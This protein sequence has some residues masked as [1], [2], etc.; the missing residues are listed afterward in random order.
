MNR[1]RAIRRVDKGIFVDLAEKMKH[2]YYT[3]RA[4]TIIITTYYVKV[5]SGGVKSK[6]IGI[7][8]ALWHLNDIKYTSMDQILNRYYLRR[9]ANSP[10]FLM[11]RTFLRHSVDIEFSP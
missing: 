6:E 4:I 8:T 1:A 9:T 5:N 7:I 11:K 2:S 10:S 3:G